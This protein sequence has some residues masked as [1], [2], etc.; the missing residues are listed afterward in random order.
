[1]LS[2]FSK[3]LSKTRPFTV[4]LGG[5]I[6]LAGIITTPWLHAKERVF[7]A[8]AAYQE[9]YTLPL[10]L[11]GH[12]QRTRFIEKTNAPS[13]FNTIERG[14]WEIQQVDELVML[15]NPATGA[16]AMATITHQHGLTTTLTIKKPL[17]NNAYCTEVLTLTPQ[18]DHLTGEQHKHCYR[19]GENTP[20]FYALAHVTGEKDTFTPDNPSYIYLSVEDLLEKD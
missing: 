13:V 5:G 18:G 12:W 19:N 11:R 20:Y 1:M 2:I 6:L 14:E 9:H 10:E 15:R 4:W 16:Q 17:A 3:A 8:G 7:R